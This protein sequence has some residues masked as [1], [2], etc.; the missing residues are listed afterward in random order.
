MVYNENKLLEA[1]LQYVEARKKY[2]VSAYQIKSILGEIAP[3][4]EKYSIDR[5]DIVS[6]E[7]FVKYA[8]LSIKAAKIK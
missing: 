3:D 8:P 5:H 6:N 7:N 2:I 1:R 4:F